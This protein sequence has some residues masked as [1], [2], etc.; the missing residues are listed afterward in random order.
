MMGAGKSAVGH[1]LAASLEWPFLDTDI[2]IEHSAKA[3]IPEIFAREG[4]DG[5][6]KRESEV[7][8]DLPSWKTVIALGGG[9]LLDER[10][11]RRL[12][13]TGT[14]IWLRASPDA[15][16]ER[17]GGGDERPLLAGLTREERRG[18]L[19]SLIA[20]RQ[21]TYATADLEID[22]DGL[23]A[24]AV[25]ERLQRQLEQGVAS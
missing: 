1:R 25:C 16:L 8:A 18:R 9:A 6:R 10:N 4:E 5:F 12:R 19:A 22:T 13:A 2:L 23:D 15:I 11:R 7:I 3:T 17:I 14:L 21:R 24:E 20:E